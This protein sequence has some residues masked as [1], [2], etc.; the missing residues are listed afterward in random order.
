MTISHRAADASAVSAGTAKS[1]KVARMACCCKL[2]D[3]LP[4]VQ[5]LHREAARTNAR[6][7]GQ[8]SEAA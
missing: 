7:A 1:V 5:Q 3:L 8:R 4:L 6:Q 2:S